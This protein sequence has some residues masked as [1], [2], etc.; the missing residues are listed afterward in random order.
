VNVGFVVANANASI[1]TSTAFIV[2]SRPTNKTY[3]RSVGAIGRHSSARRTRSAGT[4]PF[5]T[6]LDFPPMA[7]ANARAWVSRPCATA[8]TQSARSSTSRT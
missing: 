8:V 4:M 2:S 5:G 3:G 6:T 7:G 1:R